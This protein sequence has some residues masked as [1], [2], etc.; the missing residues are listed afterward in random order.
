MHMG[1]ALYEICLLL[2]A[3]HAHRD[4]PRTKGCTT[5]MMA[6]RSAL[7]VVADR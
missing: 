4:T 3:F 2:Y 1:P 7:L 5:C 6:E